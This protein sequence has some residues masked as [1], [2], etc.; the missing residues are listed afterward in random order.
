MVLRATEAE[1]QGTLASSKIWWA[2]QDF[3]LWNSSDSEQNTVLN[4]P[5]FAGLPCLNSELALIPNWSCPKLNNKPLY[6]NLEALPDPD[7][8]PKQRLTQTSKDKC[9][10]SLRLEDH[11]L[12]LRHSVSERQGT[13][14]YTFMVLRKDMTKKNMW[15]MMKMFN[16]VA[17]V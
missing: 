5:R 14:I 8:D 11:L 10:F 6:G 15:L 3:R 13:W 16:K 2:S 17:A 9:T 1:Q 4:G 12:F 7:L